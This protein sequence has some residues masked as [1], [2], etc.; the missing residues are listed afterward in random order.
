MLDEKILQLKAELRKMIKGYL[1]KNGFKSEGRKLSIERGMSFSF[2]VPILF[3][4][5]SR[6]SWDRG[7]RSRGK[8]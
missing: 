8:G 5:V 1:L 3:F 2:G 6:K 7:A 4:F